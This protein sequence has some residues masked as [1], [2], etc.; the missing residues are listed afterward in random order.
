M[1]SWKQKDPI[2]R[3]CKAL[4]DRG[5]LNAEGEHLLQERV[6]RLMEEA[7]QFATDSPMPDPA[8][9]MKDVYV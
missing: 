2:A 5:A 1:E 7:E 6:T 4:F 3:T 8:E 9:A